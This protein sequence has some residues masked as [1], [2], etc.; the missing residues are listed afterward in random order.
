[1]AVIFPAYGEKP[2]RVLFEGAVLETRERNF[3]DDS[4][5]YAV[6]WDADKQ[7]L[8]TIEYATT[9]FG[10]GGTAKADASDDVLNAAREWAD[11][12]AFK[13][14]KE[15]LIRDASTPR[16]GKRV[17]VVRGRTA[18]IGYEGEIFW[19]GSSGPEWQRRP[20][21]CG[22]S[23]SMKRKGKKYID[24]EWTYVSNVEVVDP[25]QYIP[26]DAE[27]KSRVKGKGYAVWRAMSAGVL[28]VIGGLRL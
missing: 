12:Y 22:L 9:R 16:K 4:D 5:F 26:D 19:Q 28:P 8:T 21:R 23:A 27:I 20:D 17:R 14:Y 24:A 7:E 25:D 13:W 3:H 10:G 18:P 6:C 2:K 11:A 15:A 1:M